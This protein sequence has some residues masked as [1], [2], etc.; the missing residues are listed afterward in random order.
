MNA[1]LFPNVFGVA[2]NTIIL[3]IQWQFANLRPRAVEIELCKVSN[4]VFVSKKKK[5]RGFIDFK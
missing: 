5:L 4:L 2:I 1:F 3:I